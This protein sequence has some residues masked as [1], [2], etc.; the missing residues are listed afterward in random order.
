VCG[1]AITLYQGK[2]IIL[3]EQGKIGIYVWQEKP[4]EINITLREALNFE[5]KVEEIVG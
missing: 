4:T 2:P 3:R 5:E 1:P